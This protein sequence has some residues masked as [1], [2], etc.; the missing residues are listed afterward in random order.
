M[1]ALSRVARIRFLAL[2]SILILVANYLLLKQRAL[3]PTV[4]PMPMASAA[5]LQI[6]EVAVISI[7]IS[8][9]VSLPDAE[10]SGM[11]WY[12]NTLILL[13]QYP[14]RFM[15]TAD[16]ALFGI[17]K[18]DLMA[19]LSGQTTSPLEPFEIPFYASD[20]PASIPGFE[21]F[22]AIAFWGDQVFLSIEANP[23]AM[24]GYLV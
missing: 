12:N 16:G 10:I 15:G 21:G 18:A 24:A 2:A 23:G 9:P 4:T 13:P 5:T 14:S 7:P 8:G 3:L 17:N 19:F 20:I 11:A 22:E 1:N 6:N